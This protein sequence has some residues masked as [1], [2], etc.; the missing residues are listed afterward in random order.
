MQIN[1]QFYGFGELKAFCQQI[2]GEE[3]EKPPK[4]EKEAEK[5]VKKQEKKLKDVLEEDKPKM[6]K[7]RISEEMRRDVKDYFEGGMS[8]REIADIT[9]ISFSSVMRIV[10]NK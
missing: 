8:G 7:P 4:L 6:R 3:T 9:G 1:L 5:P 10:N 2:V